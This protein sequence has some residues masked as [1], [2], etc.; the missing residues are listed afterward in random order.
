MTQLRISP[1]AE[2]DLLETWL[3]IADDNPV[4]ADSWL[5]RLTTTALRLAEFPEL[6]RG[7][8]ELSSNL[9]SFPLDSYVLFYRPTGG[10]I[11]LVRVLRSSRD[12]YQLF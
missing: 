2:Q 6:G 3:Y 1:Q 4:I 9:R 8:P 10:G 7:R 11:E 12:I 5:D